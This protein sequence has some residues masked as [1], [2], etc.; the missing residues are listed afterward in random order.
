MMKAVRVSPMVDN[1][2][3]CIKTG[4][5]RSTF[6]ILSE[7]DLDAIVAEHDTSL[8]GTPAFPPNHRV[9]RQSSVHSQI[10]GTTVGYTPQTMER[11]LICNSLN[12]PQLVPSSSSSSASRT[13][14]SHPKVA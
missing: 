1:L 3:V 14:E 13:D 10:S 7:E 4:K 11:V 12:N 6:R 2:V 9:S 8:P 5:S